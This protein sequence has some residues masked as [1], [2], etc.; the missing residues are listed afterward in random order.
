MTRAPSRRL[1]TLPAPAASGTAAGSAPP[2]LHERG[3]P[4]LE[5]RPPDC[6]RSTPLP[7]GSRQKLPPPV[8]V[9]VPEH[10]RRHPRRRRTAG[11]TRPVPG[12][13]A[14]GDARPHHPSRCPAPGADRPAAEPRRG[15]ARPG[16]AEQVNANAGLGFIISQATQFLRNDVIFVALAVYCLLGLLTD[17]LVRSLE[18]KAA[19]QPGT[20]RSTPTCGPGSAWSAAAPARPWSAATTRS[21]TSSRSTPRSGSPNSS[22]PATPTWRRRTGSASAS[23]PKLRK[24]GAL[25]PP[26]Q[27]KAPLRVSA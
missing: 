6:F 16:V 23:C 15:L 2:P 22:C 20:W 5:T 18:R 17:A 13:A 26:Y 7:P 10:L 9:A 14:P 21:Q 1:G 3:L 12:T 24:R 27:R 8:T 11:R 4:C 25:V 19:V